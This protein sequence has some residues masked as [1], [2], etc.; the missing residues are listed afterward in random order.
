MNVKRKT[1]R[2]RVLCLLAEAAELQTRFWGKLNRL[3]AALKSDIES[4][5]DLR[6]FDVDQYM[7]ARGELKADRPGA[8]S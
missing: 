5:L 6:E 4:H 7:D 2:A 1:N 8:R 3:E